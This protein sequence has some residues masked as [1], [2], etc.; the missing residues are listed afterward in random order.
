MQVPL[1]IAYQ[2]QATRQ[3]VMTP[4]IVN[5]IGKISAV[6]LKDPKYYEMEVQN[7]SQADHHCKAGEGVILGSALDDIRKEEDVHDDLC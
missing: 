6:T 4:A 5:Q 1:I 7:V 2:G 3:T